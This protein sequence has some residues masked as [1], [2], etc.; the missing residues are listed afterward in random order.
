MWEGNS[1]KNPYGCCN[2]WRILFVGLPFDKDVV[3]SGATLRRF[4]TWGGH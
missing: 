2:Q 4:S 1:V 3:C